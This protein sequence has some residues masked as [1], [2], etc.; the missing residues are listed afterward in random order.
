MKNNLI[1]MISALLFSLNVNAQNEKKSKDVSDG[2]RKIKVLNLGVFHMG[3]TP[4]A[5]ATEY[6][7]KSQKA[8]R[9]INEVTKAISKFKPTIILVEETPDRQEELEKAYKKYLQDKNVKTGYEDNEI[10]LLGFEIGSMVQAN[11]IYG[12]DH[13]MGYNYNLTSMAKKLKAENFF[14]TGRRLKELESSVV[15]DVD[16]IGLKQALLLLNSKEAYDFLININADMLMYVNSKDNF[17]GADEAT[18]FY[19]R[20]IRMFSNINK[21]PMDYDDSVLIISGGGHAA[22]FEGFMSRSIIYELQPLKDYLK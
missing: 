11:R 16:K 12:I 15:T 21:I 4:D 10:Q 9:E 7:E 22:F 6:D 14:E 17:E 13:Q 19:H 20:N 5:N 8:K 3:F 2:F 18:K 1:I